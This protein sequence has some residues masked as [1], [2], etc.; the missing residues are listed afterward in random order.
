MSPKGK[1]IPGSGRDPLN[2]TESQIRYAMENSKSNAGAARFLNINVKTYK[3]YASMYKDKVTGKD[4]FELHKN[5]DGIGISKPTSGRNHGKKVDDI[6][7]GKH[8]EY[9]RKSLK[10]RLQ[11]TGDIP[12]ICACCGF[13]EYRLDGKIPLLL[14][15]I[16]G[17]YTNHHIDNLQWLCYNHYFLTV[18]SFTGKQEKYWYGGHIDDEDHKII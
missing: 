9:P 16:D 11:K 4:L 14:N 12:M 13:N 8:P 6:L 18:G 3:K 5:Q 15:W 2:I 17:D 1:F 7:A 10:R